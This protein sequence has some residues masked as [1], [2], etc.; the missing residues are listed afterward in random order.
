MHPFFLKEVDLYSI[1][2]M[3][4]KLIYNAT[5]MLSKRYGVLDGIDYMYWSYEQGI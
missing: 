1:F 2:Q 5:Q 4:E 3:I